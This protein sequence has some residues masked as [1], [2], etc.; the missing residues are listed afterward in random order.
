MGNVFTK[1]LFL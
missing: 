1:M